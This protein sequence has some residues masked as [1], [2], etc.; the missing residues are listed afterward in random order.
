MRLLIDLKLL[1]PDEILV[2]VHRAQRIQLG[3]LKFGEEG[4]IEAS[5]KKSFSR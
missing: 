4:D 2:C 1:L 5:E 3:V